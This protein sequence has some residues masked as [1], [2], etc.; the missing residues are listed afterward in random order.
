MRIVPS[1]P[2][3]SGNYS[4]EIEVGLPVD[5]FDGTYNVFLRIFRA[6]FY[7]VSVLLRDTRPGSDSVEQPIHGA[8][9][10][11]EVL[12]GKDVRAS[13]RDRSYRDR[14]YRDRSYRHRSCVALLAVRSSIAHT[15]GP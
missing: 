8:P 11:I 7:E 13:Y 15:R 9:E 10:L 1:G 14:S 2:N 5:N 12:P 3:A 6:G 4:E